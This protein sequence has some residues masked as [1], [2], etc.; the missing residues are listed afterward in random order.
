MSV[1]MRDLDRFKQVNDRHGHAAG[2]RVLERFGALPAARAPERELVFRLGGEEFCLL[3]PGAARRARSRSPRP[4]A[5]PRATSCAPGR[6]SSRCRSGRPRA[7][8]C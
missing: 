5:A 6:T 7:G 8:R 3:L 1:L 4:C 2:D